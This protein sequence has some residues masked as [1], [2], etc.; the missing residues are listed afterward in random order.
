MKIWMKMKSEGGGRALHKNG[1]YGGFVMRDETIAD[2]AGTVESS[3]RD[4]TIPLH[5]TGH[6]RA[7]KKNHWLLQGVDV[8]RRIIHGASDQ[9]VKYH[10]KHQQA[11][12]TM[13]MSTVLV[14]RKA[15]H[16]EGANILALKF[17]I[18]K[19]LS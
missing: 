12:R 5:S 14:F 7:R 6:A 4:G 18:C 9:L 17:R 11:R 3:R 10:R 19:I 1:M 8:N 16:P 2:I 13:M 15:A